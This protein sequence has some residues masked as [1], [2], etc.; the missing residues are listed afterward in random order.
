M[1]YHLTGKVHSTSKFMR[2]RHKPSTMRGDWIPTIHTW[3]NALQGRGL[4]HLCYQYMH[5]ATVHHRRFLPG[6]EWAAGTATVQD[7]GAGKLELTVHQRIIA[8]L[9]QWNIYKKIRSHVFVQATYLFF[10]LQGIRRWLFFQTTVFHILL[11]LL[12]PVNN[13]K[14]RI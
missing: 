11:F 1:N 7:R 14:C 13:G 6:G 9:I 10:R 2:D 5:T 4:L 8:W 3:G 12:L